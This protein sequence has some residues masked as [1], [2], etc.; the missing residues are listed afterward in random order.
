MET[1]PCLYYCIDWY[2]YISHGK[3]LD[4][5]RL[6]LAQMLVAATRLDPTQSH[7]DFERLDSG[8]KKSHKQWQMDQPDE[9]TYLGI[10]LPT[11]EGLYLVLYAE[12]R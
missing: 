2:N 9:N 7:Q 5:A 4:E 11:T 1:F 6:G 10:K 3:A 12:V 8:S